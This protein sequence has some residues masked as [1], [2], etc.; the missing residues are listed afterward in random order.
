MVAVAV[1]PA[2]RFGCFDASLCVHFVG[3]AGLEG[4]Q[5][6]LVRKPAADQRDGGLVGCRHIA[7]VRGELQLREVLGLA[8]VGAVD[9]LERHVAGAEQQLAGVERAQLRPLVERG[10]VGADLLQLAVLGQRH[11]MNVLAVARADGLAAALSAATRFVLRALGLGVRSDEQHAR[12]EDLRR[13]PP[14]VQPAPGQALDDRCGLRFAHIQHVDAPRIGAPVVLAAFEQHEAS[15]DLGHRPQRSGSAQREALF[16]VHRRRD[17]HRRGVRQVEHRN[18]R[19]VAHRAMGFDRRT[20]AAARASR[21]TAAGRVALVFWIVAVGIAAWALTAVVVALLRRFIFAGFG[22]GFLAA[23]AA[24]VFVDRDADS[25]REQHRIS[26]HG[27]ALNV[28]HERDLLVPV[29]ARAVFAR[30][31]FARAVF[32]R[33]VLAWAVLFRRDCRAGYLVERPVNARGPLAASRLVRGQRDD[34]LAIGVPTPHH[35]DAPIGQRVGAVEI[36]RS[37]LGFCFVGPLRRDFGLGAGFER[38]FGEPIGAPGLLRLAVVAVVAADHHDARLV[39]ECVRDTAIESGF[40]VDAELAVC[41]LVERDDLAARR[42]P[43]VTTRVSDRRIA[44]RSAATGRNTD[45][46]PAFRSRLTSARVG[47]PAA[48]PVPWVPAH[49]GRDHDQFSADLERLGDPAIEPLHPDLFGVLSG[50]QI[51]HAHFAARPRDQ[52]LGAAIGLL[53]HAVRLGE[54]HGRL[55]AAD[56]HLHRHAVHRDRADQLRFGRCRDVDNLQSPPPIE[57]QQLVLAPQARDVALFHRDRLPAVVAAASRRRAAFASRL[58]ALVRGAGV[59]GLERGEVAF[60]FRCGLAHRVVG[61]GR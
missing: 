52:L 14:R 10:L 47:A 7:D 6:C 44:C 41:R 4:S 5:C 36:E 18:A 46:S 16:E 21:T 23:S 1:H 37:G 15:V 28:L 60:T 43:A 8:Q 17:C 19:V 30:A 20:S 57:D 34:G 59:T 2:P 54:Q 13:R 11:E 48:A 9:D 40:A 61:A 33:A 25:Q 38:D 26:G 31:V 51:D 27:S 22:V 49:L 53:L 3:A 12:I 39:D 56:V 55:A 35:D 50:L 29:F 45:G 42:A 32:A 58:A 24:I